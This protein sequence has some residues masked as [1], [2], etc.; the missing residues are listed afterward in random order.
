MYT[1]HYKAKDNTEKAQAKR[2]RQYDVKRRKPCFNV[3]DRVLRCN[4][5]RET[6]K[7][8]KLVLAEVVSKGVFCLNP[9]SGSPVKVLENSRNLKLVATDGYASP[10]KSQLAARG[11]GGDGRGRAP[12]TLPTKSPGVASRYAS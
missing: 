8:G 3:D 1:L 7:G 11:R 10:S 4:R 6:R 9:T 12:S 5:C 2:K